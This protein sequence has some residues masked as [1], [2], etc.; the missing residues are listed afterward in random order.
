MLLKNLGHYVICVAFFGST[1]NWAWSVWDCIRYTRQ[2]VSKN[3]AGGQTSS[4]VP[5]KATARAGGGQGS[6][7]PLKVANCW[8]QFS[9][10]RT[11]PSPTPRVSLTKGSAFI[12][13][14]IIPS[15]YFQHL[16][17]FHSG[18]F[19]HINYPSV[20][21]TRGSCVLMTN[22]YRRQGHD[23][24]HT[25]RS[26]FFLIAR[27]CHLSMKAM[28]STNEWLPTFAPC[29]STFGNMHLCCKPILSLI[30]THT[31]SLSHTLRLVPHL[32]YG[33]CLDY[34]G[35]KKSQL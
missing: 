24:L 19:I 2:S 23:D 30:R 9:S 29:S 12:C 1:V 8:L 7:L 21:S 14:N 32:T 10:S 16:S 26:I 15:H 28:C 25:G 33:S 18:I 13:K 27:T 20:A 6:I 3:W 17:H 5:G 4:H 31:H 34:L 11:T 22:A 35:K